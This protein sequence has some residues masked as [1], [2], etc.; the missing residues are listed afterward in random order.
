MGKDIKR[1]EQKK[2]FLKN[3]FQSILLG[4]YYIDIIFQCT[5][6]CYHSDFQ[7]I[8][9]RC[10][11]PQKQYSR[12]WQSHCEEISFDFAFIKCNLCIIFEESDQHTVICAALA[13]QMVFFAFFPRYLKTGISD[14]FLFISIL[15]VQKVFI[16]RENNFFLS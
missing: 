15:L 5:A 12:I 1:D 8:W 3:F 7:C 16:W 14:S 6:W 4:F 10:A 11:M 9:R 2:I 13:F